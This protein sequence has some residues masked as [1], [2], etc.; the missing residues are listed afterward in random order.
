MVFLLSLLS[1]C[2][3]LFLGVKTFD[4]LILIFLIFSFFAIVP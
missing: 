3:R 2:I 4:F 1:G